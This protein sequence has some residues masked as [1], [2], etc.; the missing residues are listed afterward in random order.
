[1]NTPMNADKAVRILVIE[2]RRPSFN[3]GDVP[4]ARNS[5]A[6][7]GVFIGVHRRSPL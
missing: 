1:M 3:P 2:R 4:L 6:F 5:S 7:I